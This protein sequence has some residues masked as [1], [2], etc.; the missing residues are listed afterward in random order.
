ML[1]FSGRWKSVVTEA[2]AILSSCSSSTSTFGEDKLTETGFN[3]PPKT[4][5]KLDNINEKKMVQDIG[6]QAMKDQLFPSNLNG[7]LSYYFWASQNKAQKYLHKYKYIQHP[8]RQT[9]KCPESNQ[10]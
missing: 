7:Y 3:P 6:N 9:S 8:I 2:C 10:L 1:P 4:T 5:E